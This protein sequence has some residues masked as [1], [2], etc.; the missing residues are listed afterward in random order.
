MSG[1]GE[2]EQKRSFLA[3]EDHNGTDFL[4][5]EC[6]EPP[7]CKST[8]FSFIGLASA[9]KERKQVAFE[10]VKNLGAEL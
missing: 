6:N 10:K 4:D 2:N 5:T 3:E 1:D 7:S 9:L 8:S